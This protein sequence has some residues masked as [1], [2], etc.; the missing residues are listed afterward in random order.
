MKTSRAI[1]I[2][3]ALVIVVGMLRFAHQ[4]GVALDFGLLGPRH[5]ITLHWTPS[6]GAASYKIYRT[7]VSGKGYEKVGTSTEPA[8]VDGTVAVGIVYYYAVTSVSESGAESARSS[9]IKA[10]VPQH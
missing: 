4:Q 9:E 10:V 3:L 8:F 1:W 5:K 2:V 7:T 6:P